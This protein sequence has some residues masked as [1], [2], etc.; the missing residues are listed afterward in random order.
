MLVYFA[1]IGHIYAD[2]PTLEV[3]TGKLVSKAEEFSHT[4]VDTRF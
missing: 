2:D 1:L 3:A 4:D